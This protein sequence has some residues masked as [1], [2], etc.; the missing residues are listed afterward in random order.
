MGWVLC[1]IGEGEKRGRKG[2]EVVGRGGREGGGGKRGRM[3]GG[4]GG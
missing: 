4:L 1:G 3:G 2:G